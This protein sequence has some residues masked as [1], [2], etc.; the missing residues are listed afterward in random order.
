MNTFL[1][2]NARRLLIAG[3]LAFFMGAP[4]I[5]CMGGGEAEVGEDAGGDEEKKEEKKEEAKPESKI[6]GSWQMRPPQSEMRKFKIID[7][8]V[9]GNPKKKQ[10]LGQLQGDEKK[11]F[12]E[13]AGMKGPE[14][15][16]MQN[17]LKL[18]KQNKFVFTESDVTVQFGADEKFGPVKY[19]VVSASDSAITV[20]FDPGLGNGTE[21]HAITW[22][23]ENKG[24]DQITASNGAEFLPL[25]IGKAGK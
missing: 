11:L 8:A 10:D 7:A 6:I 18:M 21:T 3:G 22:K 17:M 2:R 14:K 16:N 20:K 15:K 19:T 23:G 13:V 1:E 24:T 5:A 12:D 25:D 4:T 9:S